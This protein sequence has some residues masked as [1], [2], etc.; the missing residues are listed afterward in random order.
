MFLEV[1]WGSRWHGG[2]R[3]RLWE[4]VQV[5]QVREKGV[6]AGT[7]AVVCGAG[8]GS[9][10][11]L[12]GERSDSALHPAA[13][14]SLGTGLEMQVLQPRLLP[15]QSETLGVGPS[16]FC[17]SQALEVS[18]A[19]SS[20][21]ATGLAAGDEVTW[22]HLHPPRKG[23]TIV[24]KLLCTLLLSS[25]PHSHV[26]KQG[27]LMLPGRLRPTLLGPHRRGPQVQVPSL[28][29]GPLPVLVL[30]NPRPHLDLEG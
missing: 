24:R 8:D 5:F 25:A 3:Q 27:A 14:A 18:D 21:R 30:P 12:P 17:C 28:A 20:L 23:S 29:P 26:G 13:P 4:V 1:V 7:D 6:R 19:N 10:S 11:Y 22:S 16:N 2:K 9:C 15:T